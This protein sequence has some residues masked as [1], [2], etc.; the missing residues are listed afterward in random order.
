MIKRESEEKI[1]SLINKQWQWDISVC[2]IMKYIYKPVKMNSSCVNYKKLICLN[3]LRHFKV[4]LPL[5]L[6]YYKKKK[7]PWVSC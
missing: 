6:V 3:M 7:C 1:V 4:S 5:R 2:H